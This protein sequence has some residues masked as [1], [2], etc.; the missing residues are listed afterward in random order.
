M[1]KRVLS[2]IALLLILAS[3]SAQ[4]I[5]VK[6]DDSTIVAKVKKIG[7]S[8]IEYVKFHNQEGPVYVIEKKD[9]KVIN[10]ENGTRDTFAVPDPRCKRFYYGLFD[11][12]RTFGGKRFARG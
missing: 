4:D 8:E 7:T 11:E 1:A 5:I 10:Y 2:Y 12:G 9:V 6:H 3:A